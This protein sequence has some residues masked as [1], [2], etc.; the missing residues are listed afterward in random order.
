MNIISPAAY[1]G[2]VTGVFLFITLAFGQPAGPPTRGPE[3]YVPGALDELWTMIKAAGILGSFVLIMALRSKQG[4]V[5][6]L[7]TE[8]KELREK[9]EA[10]HER[11]L[12]DTAKTREVVQEQIS[13]TS[14]L[15]QSIANALA[16]GVRDRQELTARNRQDL[17]DRFDRQGG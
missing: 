2:T 12:D 3:S 7:K 15:V 17:E 1:I 8:N 4:E 9:N 6:E 14:K 13:T 16:V 5:D 10:L 11:Y